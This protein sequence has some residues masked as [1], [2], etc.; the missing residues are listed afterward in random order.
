MNAWQPIEEMRAD[1]RARFAVYGSGTNFAAA[2]GISDEAILS[3]LRGA[4]QP[5][6]DVLAALGWERQVFYRRVEPCPCRVCA[7]ARVE[8]DPSDDPFDP[9]MMRMFLCETCGNKRCPHA[10]DHRNACNGSNEP[11]QPGSDYEHASL[12]EAPSTPS[13]AREMVG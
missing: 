9:R 4:R 8:A 11:G 3:I 5:G 7:Q 6:P 12:P 2:N 13:E 1:L 10:T